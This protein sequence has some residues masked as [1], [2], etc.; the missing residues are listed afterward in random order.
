M[1]SF[2]FV[3]LCRTQKANYSPIKPVN[4]PIFS[5]R[6]PCRMR[7]LWFSDCRLVIMWRIG[8]CFMFKPVNQVMMSV[9]CMF[10]VSH[11]FF[12]F[13]CLCFFF[14]VVVGYSLLSCLF[15]MLFLTLDG[16]VCMWDFRIARFPFEL[17]SVYFD[18]R[19]HPNEFRALIN[20][21]QNL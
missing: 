6:T 8:S 19:R 15:H 13:C 14:I 5:P 7:K 4:R 17:L 20:Y 10:F 16:P 3:V 12:F 21:V 9:W 11:F 18:T 1:F 2:G